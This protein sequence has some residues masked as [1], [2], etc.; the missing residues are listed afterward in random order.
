MLQKPRFILP[1]TFALILFAAMLLPYSGGNENG[2][3]F[4]LE[5][6][7]AAL[8][9]IDVPVSSEFTV[10]VWVRNIPYPEWGVIGLEI[11]ITWDNLQVE[12]LYHTIQN[13]GFQYFVGPADPKAAGY[14]F[15]NNP[16][17][18]GV[19][20]VIVDDWWMNITFH[21]LAE[22]SSTIEFLPNEEFN[23]KV[24]NLYEGSTILSIVPPPYEVT[25]NQRQP[26]PGPTAGYVG[27]ESFSADKLAIMTPFLVL[28]GLILAVSTVYIIKRPKD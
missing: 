18:T 3:I 10:E 9:S 15:L 1:I 27:G 11:A 23:P 4:T 28:A 19:T 2:V 6:D 12:Y 24:I 25:C 17:D 7:G 21:C 8:S 16:S 20:P 5:Q 14:L 22:G 26:P 13:H